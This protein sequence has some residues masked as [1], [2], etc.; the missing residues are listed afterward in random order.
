MTPNSSQITIILIT[1][2]PPGR[3]LDHFSRYLVL[4]IKFL[5]IEVVIF[6]GSVH[7]VR[8]MVASEGQLQ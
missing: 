5:Q 3:R 1:C 8:K 7:S 6:F 4:L 2:G